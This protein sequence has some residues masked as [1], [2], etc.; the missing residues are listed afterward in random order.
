MDSQL[1]RV[2]VLPGGP[3]VRW[4]FRCAPVAIVL[5]ALAA[6][7]P[8]ARADADPASDVLL[9]QNAFYPY[10][11]PV[12]RALEIT[13]ET[14]LR[15][16]ARAGLPLKV[17]VIG[18]REDLGA[19]PSFFGHPQQYAEFLDREISFNDR[20]ALLVVMPA[21]F[22]VVAAGPPGT[23]AGLKVDTHE[24]SDD[25]VRSAIEAVVVLVRASGRKITA[26]SISAGSSAASAPPSIV[27]AV[28]VA[29]LLLA[30]A[31][32]GIRR[33]ASRI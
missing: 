20:P 24:S 12:S 16:A 8:S 23:L 19:V 15:A 4:I 6:C 7:V 2:R 29:V 11:P 33:R 30:I 1:K 27:F 10:E 26:P 31:V 3:L 28:P 17:A 32:V 18:S 22:G 21:G 5:L 14:I 9:A 13:M 25:L